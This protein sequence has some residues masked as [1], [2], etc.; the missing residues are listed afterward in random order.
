MRHVH[1]R[2]VL[3]SRYDPEA[4][5]GFLE[6]F[7]DTAEFTPD[8]AEFESY[9]RFNVE[10]VHRGLGVA[11]LL[12]RYTD[13]NNA[14]VLDIGAGSG[15][16]TIAMAHSGASV[17]AI[18]PDETRRRWWRSRIAGHGA[19]A[20]LI[21]SVAEALPFKDGT[22]DI[23]LC[24]SVIEHVRDPAVTIREI[25]RVLRRGGV[26][27]L[28]S[29]NKTSLWNVW[30]DPHYRKFAVVMMPRRVGTFYIERVR[31]HQRGYWVGKIPTR[32]WLRRRFTEVGVTLRIVPLAGVDKLSDPESLGRR[33]LRLVATVVAALRLTSFLATIA[34]N[35]RPAFE[36][37]G[38]KETT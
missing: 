18:E 16:L 8:D 25:A 11:E 20:T 9:L 12:S 31:R 22:F 28:V 15:G 29:P 38:R 34:E 10:A 30:R 7:L 1:R 23:V 24:D 4:D 3:P 19:R 5:N 17:T 14:F 2:V 21:D 32:R 6:L 35:Q 13:L 36:F 37:V 26:V 33:W 27:Y